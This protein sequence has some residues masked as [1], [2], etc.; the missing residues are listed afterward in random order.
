MSQGASTKKQPGR[1]PKEHD[2]DAPL[3]PKM[4]RFVDEYL[5]DFN[6]T[7]AAIRAGYAKSGAH[8]QAARL[9]NN[10]KVIKA[11]QERRDRVAKRFELTR[12]RL[13]EEYCKLAFSDPRKFFREDGTLKT[14]PE[15]DDETAAALAH[16]EVMEEFDGSGENRMQV[17]YTSKVKWTDKR[18]ALDSIARVMGWNQD[19]MK[20]QGDAE[21]PLTMLLKQVSGTAFTPQGEGEP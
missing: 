13:I 3:S 21:N 5:A 10:A 14:I 11:I 17:G 4:E 12:E 18:A 16:F 2:V 6:G 15:L 20:L 9:L 19:K 8:V 1:K 7:Q